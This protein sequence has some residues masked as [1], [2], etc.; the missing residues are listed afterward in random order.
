MEIK[1]HLIDVVNGVSEVVVTAPDFVYL[2]REHLRI[3]DERKRLE[4]VVLAVLVQLSGEELSTSQLQLV[5]QRLLHHEVLLDVGEV[6]KRGIQIVE[7]RNAVVK[8]GRER[9][10]LGVNL[11]GRCVILSIVTVSAH[12]L[13]LGFPRPL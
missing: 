7:A 8:V 12:L 11:L 5:H 6:A 10:Q 2:V 1:K 13:L 9:S 4:E 3:N